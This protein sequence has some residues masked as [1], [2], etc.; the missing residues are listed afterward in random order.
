MHQEEIGHLTPNTQ[1]VLSH[2]LHGICPL[3]IK[4]VYGN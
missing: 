2:I 3:F 1:I 4:H